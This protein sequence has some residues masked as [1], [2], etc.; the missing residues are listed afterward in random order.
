VHVREG[1]ILN[2]KKIMTYNLKTNSVLYM[3][4]YDNDFKIFDSYTNN[5]LYGQYYCLEFL[6]TSRGTLKDNA[7]NE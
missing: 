7:M 2:L 1:G 3:K 4:L 6:F 5:K